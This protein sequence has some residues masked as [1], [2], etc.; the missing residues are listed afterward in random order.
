MIEVAHAMTSE[1]RGGFTGADRLE[2]MGSIE[3]LRNQQ[4]W[5]G[6]AQTV[7]RQPKWERIDDKAFPARN[8]GHARNRLGTS[9]KS[10]WT[11]QWKRGKEEGK[12]KGNCEIRSHWSSIRKAS[13][14][15]TPP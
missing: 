5:E 15:G 8:E 11:T 13:Y 12:E 7:R 3:A 1:L 6:P 4:H 14:S 10:T 2:S 9:R